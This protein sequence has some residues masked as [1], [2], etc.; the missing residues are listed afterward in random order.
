MPTVLAERPVHVSLRIVLEE[1]TCQLHITLRYR[2]ACFFAQHFLHLAVYGR[3]QVLIGRYKSLDIWHG[4]NRVL[5]CLL[6]LLLL[7]LFL[8]LCLQIRPCVL[9]SRPS[10]PRMTG[11][12]KLA[13]DGR[14][15]D[16]EVE[17]L[18]Q[19]ILN[20]FKLEVVVLLEDGDDSL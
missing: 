1:W 2:A 15:G 17:L 12:R 16:M 20:I 4:G 8:F 11:P 7:L 3:L 6:L 18:L 5:R 14:Y 13:A 19:E 9:V 10:R